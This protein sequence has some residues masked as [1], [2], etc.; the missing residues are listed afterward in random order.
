MYILVADKCLEFHGNHEVVRS[1]S[2]DTNVRL[3]I[4][5]WQMIEAQCLT[6]GLK[7]GSLGGTYIEH[8][9]PALRTKCVTLV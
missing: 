7:D 9:E 8:C 4:V 5:E 3:V 1:V 6:S 2:K